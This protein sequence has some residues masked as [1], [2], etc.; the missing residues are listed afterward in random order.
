MRS[1]L[2]ILALGLAAPAAADPDFDAAVLAQLNR[3]RTQPQSFIEDLRAF[4]QSF[5]AQGHYRNLSDG[6]LWASSEGAAAVD[7]AIA[8]LEKMPPRPRLEASPLLAAAAADHTGEQG[9][10]GSSGHRSHDGKWPSDRLMA[11]GGGSRVAEALSYG[12]GHPLDVVIQLIVDDG[13]SGRGHRTILLDPAYDHAGAGCGIHRN[14]QLMCT[15]AL[16]NS[17]DGR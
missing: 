17:K 7:E 4:R 6:R 3:A 1:V 16:S 12:Q 15:I 13:V 14:Y 11:R 10:R 8:Y 9:P 2:A 5:N